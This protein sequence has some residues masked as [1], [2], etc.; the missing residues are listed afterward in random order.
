V[1]RIRTW[2]RLNVLRCEDC[3][4]VGHSEICGVAINRL[5]EHG[6]IFAPSAAYVLTGQ[7]RQPGIL[8]CVSPRRRARHATSDVVLEVYRVSASGAST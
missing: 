6:L 7:R 3:T 5:A 8:P 2:L 4:R 1:S